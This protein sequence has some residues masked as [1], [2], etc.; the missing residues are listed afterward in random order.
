MGWL[1]TARH[2]AVWQPVFG[3]SRFVQLRSLRQFVLTTYRV[4]TTMRYCYCG[5]I[6]AAAALGKE[7]GC[8]WSEVRITA[9]QVGAFRLIRLQRDAII[10]A[11]LHHNRNM[12]NIHCWRVSSEWRSTSCMRYPDANRNGHERLTWPGLHRNS[13]WDDYCDDV[14]SAA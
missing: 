9:L 3:E 12:R 13:Y 8:C 7:E 10:P 14:G 2:P 4:D 5:I 6:T 1:R 11:R